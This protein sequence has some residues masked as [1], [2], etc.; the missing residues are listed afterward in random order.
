VSE[1]GSW[2]IN[3]DILTTFF[4]LFLLVFNCSFVCRNMATHKRGKAWTGRDADNLSHLV[5]MSRMSKSYICSTLSPA[6]RQRGSFIF[7]GEKCALRLLLP[8]VHTQLS[9]G[10][11]IALADHHL[12][13]RYE[14]M[15]SV[16]ER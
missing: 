13:V 12:L 2:G 3:S 5:Q 14:T 6:W 16:T 15:V 11:S 10:F 1:F 4:C 8:S 7:T 9:T